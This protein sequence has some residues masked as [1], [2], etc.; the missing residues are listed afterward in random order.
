MCA[1]VA[2]VAPQARALS[3]LRLVLLSARNEVVTWDFAASAELAATT[4][5]DDV[6]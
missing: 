3:L 2:S 4:V 6:L 1:D 5:R